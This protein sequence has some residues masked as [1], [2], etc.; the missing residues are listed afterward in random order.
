M[1]LDTQTL[2]ASPGY[3]ALEAA[4]SGKRSDTRASTRIRMESTASAHAAMHRI[5]FL[6]DGDRYVSVKFAPPRHP[7]WGL[8][9]AGVWHR[10]TSNRTLEGCAESTNKGF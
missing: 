6:G 2:K 5:T 3:F 8:E 9:S 7:Y 1:V 4:P 10:A